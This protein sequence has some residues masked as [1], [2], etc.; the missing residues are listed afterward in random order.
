LLSVVVEGRV[1]EIGICRG[2]RSKNE[3][4]SSSTPSSLLVSDGSVSKP[5]RSFSIP[6]DLLVPF[7]K[8]WSQGGPAKLNLLVSPRIPGGP[9]CDDVVSLEG[10]IQL[11]PILKELQAATDGRVRRRFDVVCRPEK[12]N[13]GTTDPFV[14]QISA[15][16]VLVAE[17]H[18]SLDINLEPR[19]VIA[20]NMPV[21]I[22]L[23][24]PMPHTFSSSPKDESGTI[25]TIY[26]LAPDA[27]VEVFT[28]G[29]SIAVAVK[30]SDMPVGGTALDWMDGGWIDLPLVPEFR[31]PEPLDCMFPFARSHSPDPLSRTGARGSEFFISEGRTSLSAFISSRGSK[32]HRGGAD[33]TQTDEVELQASLPEDD[34]LRTFYVT[35]CYYA[36]DHTGNL[37]FEQVVPPSG[38]LR[39]SM[40]EV[41]GSTTR[42]PSSY[43]ISQPFGA[44]ASP[45][46]R[47]RISLLPCT[48]VPL[49]LL[50]LTMDGD[51]G[52]KKSSVSR[53][54]Q[55]LKLSQKNRSIASHTASLLT[56]FLS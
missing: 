22:N 7:A 4:D 38:T 24:T 1:H 10:I 56:A 12:R 32:G 21:G 19:A 34:N 42:R 45:R 35:V 20:N 51:E 43:A 36:V 30:T 33:S 46:H 27:H 48:S 28:P 52:V 16:M 47:R 53:Q 37:L 50:E 26:D 17:G 29:P 14:V 23:R 25:G 11:D 55:R 54:Q 31:L 5:S 18:L 39:R 40:T 44:F 8:E 3:R 6:L 41:S 2:N 13:Q 49:R 9:E 15:E